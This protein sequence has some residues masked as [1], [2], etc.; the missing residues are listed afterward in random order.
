MTKLQIK[1]DIQESLLQSMMKNYG[2]LKYIAERND[3]ADKKELELYFI[4]M[5]KQIARVEKLFGYEIN[6][7]TI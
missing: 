4:E 2:Y 7:F 3:N 1:Q 6:S 5:R